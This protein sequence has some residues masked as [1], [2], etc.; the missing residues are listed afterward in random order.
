MNMK[1]ALNKK[2][3]SKFFLRAPAYQLLGDSRRRNSLV[4]K[5]IHL[6]NLLTCKM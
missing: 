2:T 1:I 4:E 3:S 5:N 6:L